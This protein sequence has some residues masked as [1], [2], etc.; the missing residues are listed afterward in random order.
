MML[1]KR[2]MILEGPAVI[3]VGDVDKIT[4]KLEYKQPEVKYEGL[5]DYKDNLSDYN[6]LAE[7]FLD[8]RGLDVAPAYELIEIMRQEHP[9]NFHWSIKTEEIGNHQGMVWLYFRIIPK[10]G[11][12]EKRVLSTAQKIE[13]RS[14][15]FFLL[16]GTTARWLGWLGLVMGSIMGLDQIF[17]GLSKVATRFFGKKE[18]MLHLG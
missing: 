10:M 3:R 16:T 17:T 13:I 7:A 18:K 1:Q 14:I 11:G 12:V 5:S 4:L 9:V 6:I 8:I 15:S 2:E